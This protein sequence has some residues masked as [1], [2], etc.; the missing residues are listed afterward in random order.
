MNLAMKTSYKNKGSDLDRHTLQ[1]LHKMRADFQ[2]PKAMENTSEVLVRTSTDRWLVG[3]KSDDREFYVIFD[4]KNATLL[5]VNGIPKA[6][7][8]QRR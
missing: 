8:A 3:R 7:T 4:S 2:T 6:L 1:L 5:E